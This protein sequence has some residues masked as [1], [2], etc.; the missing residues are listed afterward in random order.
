M[1]A[2]EAKA[3]AAAVAAAQQSAKA[4]GMCKSKWRKAQRADGVARHMLT[5]QRE[6]RAKG[7]AK[8]EVNG[9]D[10]AR[11][12]RLSEAHSKAHDAAKH[13][14]IKARPLETMQACENRTKCT[15][16]ARMQA[17]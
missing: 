17:A 12:Q 15:V 2:T 7:A 1:A 3:A 11:M 4:I 14:Q 13:E 8:R 10:K 9:A 16:H 5:A 6:V